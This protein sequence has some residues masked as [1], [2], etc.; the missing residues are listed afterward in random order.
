MILA[1]DQEKTASKVEEISPPKLLS[2]KPGD[3]LNDKPARPIPESRRQELPPRPDLTTRPQSHQ[4]RQVEPSRNHNVP[5]RPDNNSTSTRP[6]LPRLSDR[7][8][9]RLHTRDNNNPRESEYRHPD[10]S[11][12]SS[13]GSEPDRRISGRTY[14]RPYHNNRDQE[15]SWTGDRSSTS[16]AYDEEGPLN[17]RPSLRDDKSD[18]THRDA[19]P[20]DPRDRYREGETL[21]S[22]SRESSR[23]PRSAVPI[24]SDRTALL[25]AAQ[26]QDRSQNVG[27]PD[28]R[29]E[30]T[31]PDHEHVPPRESRGSSP[32][33]RGE[34]PS[35]RSEHKRYD[36]RQTFDNRRPAEQISPRIRNDDLR[37]YHPSRSEQHSENPSNSHGDQSRDDPR[38]SRS[39]RPEQGSNWGF[40]QDTRPPARQQDSNYGRLNQDAPSGPRS[41]DPN[42]VPLA[43]RHTRQ[44][45]SQQ[46]VSESRSSAASNPVPTP[47]GPASSR[48]PTRSASGF[49]RP[50]PISTTI[51][52]ATTS[53]S[54]S[55]DA[56]GIHPD[57][58]KALQSGGTSFKSLPSQAPA[59][60]RNTVPESNSARSGSGATNGSDNGRGRSD[61]RFA[62]LNNVLSQTNGVPV[63]DRPQGSQS[64]GRGDQTSSTSSPITNLPPTRILPP[65][66]D[67]TTRQDQV[68]SRPPGNLARKADNTRSQRL[69]DRQIRLQEPQPESPRQRLMHNNSREYMRLPPNGD[70]R[71]DVRGRGGP[72]PHTPPIN[73]QQQPDRERGSTRE[74]LQGDRNTRRDIGRDEWADQRTGPRRDIQQD[75]GGNGRKRLRGNEEIYDQGQ[76]PFDQSKRPRRG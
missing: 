74:N 76:T 48:G 57:R 8:P 69:D 10:R 60:P 15:P 34:E 68:P 27:Y 40:K 33:R 62:Q 12:E 59:G 31:R 14:D 23:T 42:L 32:V 6:Q 55:P 67:N 52:A 50:Q 39:T 20:I 5:L 19:P 51:S 13:K 53:T 37:S 43:P 64:Q 24:H 22:K 63:S 73:H 38:N 25:K 21:E 28:R 2:S 29:H 17:T 35:S 4:L 36:D 66:A 54:S 47:S 18:R 11:Y 46:A 3:R 70:G 7:P 30:P 65:S 58:L 1:S 61:K 44:V 56:A 49:I 75:S 41:N 72:Q 45:S 71:G 26:E 9:D 16:R